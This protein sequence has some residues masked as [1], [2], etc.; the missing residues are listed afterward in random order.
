M[1]SHTTYTVLI[2]FRSPH[3]LRSWVLALMSIL[4]SAALYLAFMPNRAP[5]QARLVLRMGFTCLRSI[6]DVLRI[7]YDPDPVPDDPIQ[8]TYEEFLGGVSRMED[9]GL[10]L[11]RTP[12]EAWPHFRGWRVNY[13]SIAYRLADATVAPPGPWSGPRHHLPGMAIAVVRP[14]NRTPDNPGAG[15]EKQTRTGWHL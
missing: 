1:E 2:F 14:P 13:E 4:D 3:P 12:E 15:R 9:M 6:A 8:L 11:E 5:T 7:P 10:Q